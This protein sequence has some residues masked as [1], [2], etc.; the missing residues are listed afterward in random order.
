MPREVRIDLLR[1]PRFNAKPKPFTP[2]ERA[3]FEKWFTK[4][5]TQ[6]WIEPSTARHSSA[7]LFVPKADSSELRCCVNYVMLN[8]CTKTRIYAPSTG[9][10]QRHHIATMTWYSK[11]DL[12]DAFHNLRLYPPDRWKTAFRTPRGLY[13]WKVLPQGLH[14][15]PGEFQLFMEMILSQFL[16]QQVS[17]HIDDILI[18]TETRHECED[19]TRQVLDL[20]RANDLRVSEK[21]SVYL[22]RKIMYCGYLYEHG[23]IT[24]KD[25]TETIRTWPR[26]RNPTELRAFLGT[27]NQLR[28]HIP[29]L[30]HARKPLDELTGKMTW[31]WTST[32]ES[33]FN[34]IREIA[35]HIITTTPHNP[36]QSARLTTDASLFGIGAI[37]SQRG[38]IT[39]IWSRSLTPAERNYPANERELLAVV[40]A[41]RN[42]RHFLETCPSILVATDSMI[43]AKNIKPND[44]NRRINRWILTL[45]EYRLT[46]QHVPGKENPADAPSRRRDYIE[47]R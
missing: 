8:Q 13:Q 29:G 7:L 16:G 11:I 31:R 38:R 39:A 45:Q 21:K 47:L 25:R 33:A 30:A 32:H 22:T 43:N 1:E 19:V 15:A 9:I 10:E 37:L 35:C 6:D 24:P 36:Q 26:P 27:I 34:R 42:W 12:E 14:L 40:E 28:D 3:A 18:H 44:S 4:A 17:I 23:K 2:R 46:W 41:L 20:L 5:I